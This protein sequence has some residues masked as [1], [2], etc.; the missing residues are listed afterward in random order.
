MNI[1]F[2]FGYGRVLERQIFS[3]TFNCPKVT[4]VSC[5]QYITPPRSKNSV[6]RSILSVTSTNNDG[7]GV[8]EMSDRAVGY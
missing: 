4:S 7:K 8:F 2:G 5:L 1:F 3:P 6:G